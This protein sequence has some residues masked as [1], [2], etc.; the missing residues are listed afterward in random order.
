VRLFGK[1][2]SRD[3]GIDRP[4]ETRRALSTHESKI[5]EQQSPDAR[6]ASQDS[7]LAER[8]D[9]EGNGRANLILVL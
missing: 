2:S 4:A 9:A 6:R 1:M 5:D 3:Q 7:T 8:L